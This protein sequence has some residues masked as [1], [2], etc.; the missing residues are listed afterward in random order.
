MARATLTLFNCALHCE[1]FSSGHF[2]VCSFRR[3]ESLRS[4]SR[5]KTKTPRLDVI[6]LSAANFD[7]QSTLSPTKGF[8]RISWLSVD[9]T[10]RASLFSRYSRSMFPLATLSWPRLACVLW[11]NFSEDGVVIAA[12]EE[13]LCTGLF[14]V[15]DRRGQTNT[16]LENK[17]DQTPASN[18]PSNIAS[19]L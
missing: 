19:C 16:S 18:F 7:H 3:L 1:G 13:H 11:P 12:M 14:A 4:S 8:H 15:T 2:S 5:S 9:A 6:E 17:L 10:F